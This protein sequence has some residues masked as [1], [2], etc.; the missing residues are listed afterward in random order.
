M[1][2]AH[3]LIHAGYEHDLAHMVDAMTGYD[4]FDNIPASIKPDMAKVFLLATEPFSS[5]DNNPDLPAGVMDEQNRYKLGK[6][7]VHNA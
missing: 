2:V 5:L 6:Q 3:N 1:T 4:F 7:A